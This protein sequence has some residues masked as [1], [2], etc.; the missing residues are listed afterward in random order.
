MPVVVRMTDGKEFL[1]GE[2][3]IMFARCGRVM[4]IVAGLLP[5]T[6]FASAAESSSSG[7]SDTQQASLRALGIQVAIPTYVPSG[8][9]VAKV[10]L[11]PCPPN[12]SRNARGVCGRAPN[13]TILYRNSANNCFALNG[14]ADGIGG[15]GFEFS[16]TVRTEILGN[17]IVEFGRDGSQ[18][19]SGRAKSE[20]VPSPEQLKLP[21]SNLYSFPAG[22]GP[23][24]NVSVGDGERLYGCSK[25]S[26]ITPLELEKILKSL[27]WLK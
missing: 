2:V 25:N 21:Q 4:L 6:I 18:L 26:S 19:R 24:Y 22:N 15:G 1:K 8:F 23:Y 14:I 3:K 11:K 10:E 16:Y 9:Q 27:V 5:L 13:Y 20:Q 12:S 7:L 17:I